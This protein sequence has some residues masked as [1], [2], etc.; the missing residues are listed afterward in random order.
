MVVTGGIDSLRAATLTWS[1]AGNDNEV[2]NGANW[3]T[4]NAPA[5]TGDALI[6][7]GS[8]WL[9]PTLSSSRSVTSVTFNSAAS[10][11]T[12]GGGGTYTLTA[13]GGIVNSSSNLQ[14]INN[15]LVF[16]NN[17]SWATNVGS[18]VIN[19]NIVNSG[20]LLTVSHSTGTTTLN[21]ILSGS[22]GIK[23]SGTGGTLVLNGANAHTGANTLGAGKV[24]IGSN[25]AL[26]TGAIS[27]NSTSLNLSASAGGWSLANTYTLSR[28][29]LFSGDNS[30]I[31]SGNSVLGANR[32]VT[33]SG[34]GVLSMTGAI[35]GSSRTLTKAGSG[36]LLLSGANSMSKVT[37]SAGTLLAGNASALSTGTFSLGTASFGTTSNLAFA[38]AVSL[39][40]NATFVGDSTIT[41]NGNAALTA[42]R[43][44]NFDGSSPVTFN[45]V[46]SGSGFG[47]TKSG[48]GA[49]VLGGTSANTFTGLT[50]VTEGQLTLSKTAALNAIAGAL[51]IGDGSGDDASAIVQLNASNQ[52][53][54]TAAVSI[55]SGGQLRLQSFS[56]TVGALTLYGGS[57]TGAGSLGLGGNL[58]F[59]GTNGATASIS[60]GLGMTAVRTF[61]VNSNGLAGIDLTISGNIT[62]AFAA[63]K[64]GAGNLLLSGTN[65]FSGGFL[66][67][68][69]MTVLGSSG[70]LGTAA[71]NLGD[72]TGANS[73][74][75]LFGEL[76]GFTVANAITVRSGSSGTA[77][78]GGWNTSGV[79]TFTGAIALNKSLILTAEAGGEVTFTTGA[80]TGAGGFTKTGAGTI[81]LSGA[82]STSGAMLISE[83]T[84]AMG[85][86]N[87][88]GSGSLTVD[89][90]ILDFGANRSD[91]VAAVI[92]DNGGSITG[93]GTSILTSTSSFDLRSGLVQVG[94]AGGVNLSKTTT[95]SVTLSGV[96]NYTGTTTISAG[97]LNLGSNQALPT[98]TVLSVSSGATLA[99]QNFATQSGSLTGSG[100]IQ[101]GSATFTTG[102]L[103]TTTSFSGIISGTGG[104][105]K[106]GTGTLTLSGSNTYSGATTISGGTLAIGKSNALNSLTAVTMNSGTLSLGGFSQTVG[107]LSGSGSVT[108]DGGTFGIGAAG[109]STTY[110]GSISGSGGLVKSGAGTL[111][112][113]AANTTTASLVIDAGTISLNGAAGAL[114]TAS[115]VTLNSGGSLILDN[116]TIENANRIGNNTSIQLNGGTFSLISDSNGTNES[117]GSLIVQGGSSTVNVIHNG[118]SSTASTLTFS[119]LGTIANGATVN[120]TATG[121]ILGADATD[122]QIKITGQATG[123]LGG[124]ATVGADSAEYYLYGVRAYSD[125]DESDLGININNTLK[126]VRLSGTSS[127][128][129]NVLSN[130]GVTLNLGLNLTDIATVDLGNSSSRTLNL[131]GGSLIKSTATATTISGAGN[132]TAGG[133]AAGNLNASVVSGSSLTID[134]VITNNTVGTV[135]LTK[136]DLGT[137]T[138][139]A[140]NTFTGNVFVNEGVVSISSENNLGNGSKQVIF[141]GGTLR[142]TSGYNASSAKVLAI[143]AGLSGTLDIAAAQVLT[144]A[145]SAGMLTSGSTA[146]TLIKTGTGSLVVQNANSGFIGNL[147]L[148]Q[149]ITELRNAGSAG[150][151]NLN[152]NGGTLSLNQNTSTAYNNSGVMLTNNTI[153]VGRISGTGSVTHTLGNID[154]GARTLTVTGDGSATLQLSG[155]TLSGSGTLNPTTADLRVGVISGSN[156]LTKTGSGALVLFGSSTY[157]G[158]TNINAG[159]LRLALANVIPDASNV[160]LVSGTIFDLAGFSETIGALS[161]NGNVSLGSATL[162]TGATTSTYSGIIS[163][164]GGL[165]KNGAGTFTLSGANTY[166]GATTVSAG[167]LAMSGTNRLA[168]STN[169]TVASGA[170][171]QLNGNATSTAS[172]AGAGTISLG[173]GT[174]TTG[175]ATS[176]FSGVISGTGGLVKSGIGTLTLSGSSTYSGSTAIQGGTLV[177]RSSTA[178]GATTG[179]VS[180]SSGAVLALENNISVS[181][182]KT[183]SLAGS[184][185]SGGGALINNSGTNTWAGGISLTTG[186]T[187]NSASGGSL[188]LSGAT[189]LGNSTLTLDGSG[190]TTFSGVVSGSA[191]SNTTA[192]LKNGSGTLLL[193]GTNTFTGITTVNQGTLRIGSNAALG[194]AG[195]GNGTIVAAGATLL[196]QPPSGLT[197]GNE[198]LTLNGTG[199]GGNGAL[200]SQTGTNSWGGAIT[201]ATDSIIRVDTGS[202]LNLIGTMLESGGAKSL[203]KDGAGTLTISNIVSSSGSILLQG[204]ILRLGASERFNDDLALS[205]SAGTTFDLDNNDE[206]LGSLAGSGSITLGS[207]AEI[208]GGDL[209]TGANHSSATFSGVISGLGAV[210]K[211][212]TGTQTFS[213]SNTYTGATS[214]DGGI[215]SVSSLNN[216]G[217]AS[218]IGA[219]TNDAANLVLDGGIL[220]YTGATQSTTRLYT[221]E[222]GGG[223]FDASGSGVLTLSGAATLGGTDTARTFSLSGTNTG[224][225]TLAAALGDNGTGATS[226]LKSGTGTWVLTGAHSYTGTTTVTGG[227]L[228]LGSADRIGNSSAVVISS[229]ATFDF[230]GF[231]DAI[232]SL[233]GAGNVVLGSASM[234]IGTDQ[235]STSF[236]GI[237][238]GTGAVTK[239]GSGVQ[240]FTGNNSYTGITTLSGGTLSVASL[241]NGN[242]SSGIGASSNAAAN[243][244]INGGMLRYTGGTQSTDRNFTIGALGGGFESSG[245]GALTLTGTVTLSST[246]TARTITLGGS[247]TGNNTYS[248]A[249]TNNG[250]GKTSLNKTGAGTWRLTG[251]NTYTGTTTVSGGTLSIASGASLGAT[252]TTVDAGATLINNGNILGL[253]TVNGT[254][255]GGGSFSSAVNIQNTHRPGNSPGIQTFASGLAYAATA[256]LE[257]ELSNNTSDLGLAGTDFDQGRVTGGLFEVASGASIQLM[258]NQAGSAVDFSNNFWESNRSW[259][260]I[261]LSGSATA[262]P[263]N[264]AFSIS[265]TSLDSLGQN[266]LSYGTFTTSILNGN[267]VLNWTAVPEPDAAFLL[268]LGVSLLLR[269]RR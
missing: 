230:N 145:D 43:V 215:L 61:L 100:A 176:T 98:S 164:S 169:L 196:L 177:M 175:S 226:L 268:L 65:T 263:S 199:V 190:S 234:G 129:A 246:N 80:V 266:H 93:S 13:S 201:L 207:D 58:T 99:L 120:F 248:T 151:G 224:A 219:S 101:L 127:V 73:A 40:G 10:S 185:I 11:F 29:L 27:F 57:I 162:T 257:W 163:G 118:G 74:S 193:S 231:S 7:T 36:T 206:T 217:S 90:G 137:L 240:S 253:V 2:L 72:T 233:A 244:V 59:S 24:V 107:G 208:G 184:G 202:T 259:S 85:A 209:T 166:S 212:G 245:T 37:L 62:G 38:N 136:G 159:T 221:I 256:V 152:F 55:Y 251:A 194:A 182:S 180:V 174:L 15:N 48:T 141:N 3:S 17:Q 126:I 144:L 171:F 172:L 130:A 143:S 117:V 21:G 187:I 31:L 119:S 8:S 124:W 35:S 103:N 112:L 222:T 142:V 216:G 157:T 189:G 267:Q 76:S 16:G 96:G 138:L 205:L 9:L 67:N 26:G 165:T 131:S 33:V 238:S 155:I 81:R 30:L 223:G 147:R 168:S 22:G 264:S 140:A 154:L 242:V 213:G 249:I 161:G 247:N 188:V 150:S 227:T 191:V 95:G 250:T 239:T 20:Y 28:N 178:L 53:I 110:S 214:I 66:A 49:M 255:S 109:L 158:A 44:L 204:G 106:T 104:L 51:E 79:N 262:N 167:I 173:S 111:T 252:A 23:K 68:Q 5:L 243:L 83:G 197:I 153:N 52:I 195:S 105:A 269:R 78:L 116:A 56:D 134:S 75:M 70:A 1:G 149:G 258:F 237:I 114:A 45:G 229:G 94:L 254:L 121:G 133:V 220:R 179:A 218:G 198:A 42:S 25:S 34:A 203:T 123:L 228:R 46:V 192:V 115:V 186:S 146:S 232:G 64:T 87:T 102:G 69:G 41:F 77:T 236:S 63:T 170:T 92:L 19:G 84:L 88:L 260:V 71:A 12:L 18:T 6:F 148:D 225:N 4:G 86:S 82:N 60:S 183:L 128:G 265:S 135:G 113:T 211:T 132:L 241:A 200:Y 108:L 14:T 91:S 50:K 125:Y 32:T 235:T 122:P 261:A 181:S 160:T 97:T 54:D 139:G 47:I 39:A 89:G 156:D 210:T